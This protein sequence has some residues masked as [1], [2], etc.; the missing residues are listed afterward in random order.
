M[1]G[2]G[3]EGGGI[4][5]TEKNGYYCYKQQDEIVKIGVGCSF[6]DPDN[7]LIVMETR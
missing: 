7:W 6:L 1:W 5:R 3:N 2:E 4:Q